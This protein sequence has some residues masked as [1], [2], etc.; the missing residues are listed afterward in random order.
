LGQRAPRR[1]SRWRRRPVDSGRHALGWSVGL[2][3]EYAFSPAW[4]GKVEY[5]YL[6]FNNKSIGLRDCLLIAI[7]CSL[8][9]PWYPKR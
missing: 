8:S 4:S 3:V 5:D 7:V 6:N 9:L 1:R 2:G